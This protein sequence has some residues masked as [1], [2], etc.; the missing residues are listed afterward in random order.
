MGSSTRVSVVRVVPASC[1]EVFTLVC[2]P[3]MH[4]KIDGSGMLVAAPGA[5]PVTAVGD[6]FAMDMDREPLGDVPLGKYQVTNTITRIEP[7][8]LV[9][10]SVGMAEYP[11]VGHV[12]GYE[13]RPLDAGTSEVT[14]YCDWAAMNPEYRDRITFPIVPVSMMEQSM[15]NLVDLVNGQR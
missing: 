10:W 13:L 11:P 5:R 7:D 12:Y 15:Q 6:Q 3:A 8:Q 1:A 14:S 4:V 9:E 2:D